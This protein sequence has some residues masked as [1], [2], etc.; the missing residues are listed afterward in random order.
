MLIHDQIIY[1]IEHEYP[2]LKHGRDFVIA[3]PLDSRGVQSGEPF[4]M[5]WRT[6]TAAEPSIADLTKIFNEQYASGFY[7]AI[8]RKQRDF[9]LRQTA[10]L[11]SMLEIRP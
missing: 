9:L 8:A 10:Y 7:A 11:L 5:E 6:T 4:I 1:A 2:G 3:H